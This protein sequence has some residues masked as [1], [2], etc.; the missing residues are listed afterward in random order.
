MTALILPLL[1]L[2]ICVLSFWLGVDSTDRDA[3]SNGMVWRDER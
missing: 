3:K 1:L 2:A